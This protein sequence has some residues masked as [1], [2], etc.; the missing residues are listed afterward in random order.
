MTIYSF[1]QHTVQNM[2]YLSHKKLAC[3]EIVTTNKHVPSAG[4]HYAAS[5][6]YKTGVEHTE[7]RYQTWKSCYILGT[8]KRIKFIKW[9]SHTKVPLSLLS[10]ETVWNSQKSS[11]WQQAQ[12]LTWR[13][14]QVGFSI[15]FKWTHKKG[16]CKGFTCCDCVWTAKGYQRGRNCVLEEKMYLWKKKEIPS[17][18]TAFKPVDVYAW[19]ISLTTKTPYLKSWFTWNSLQHD[20]RDHTL[21]VHVNTYNSY[22]LVNASDSLNVV[23]KWSSR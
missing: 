19:N 7:S 9:Q 20:Y 17:A 1:W 16:G 3:F 8:D 11:S 21:T 23:I 13:E 12:P 15:D 5:E 4:A 6:T 18:F 2:W 22:H 10:R 14:L